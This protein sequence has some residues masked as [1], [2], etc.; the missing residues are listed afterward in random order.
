MSA[1]NL[2]QPQPTWPRLFDYPSGDMRQPFIAVSKAARA[3]LR[4]VDVVASRFKIATIEGEPGVGKETLAG[5]LHRRSV[6]AHE[7]LQRSD[8]R[9]WLM[10]EVTLSPSRGL[11]ILIASIYSRRPARHC[12][13]ES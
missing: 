11:S 8:A 1:Q 12:C 7:N 3:L 13:C 5:W 10:A 2:P 6:H 9:E 4:Q